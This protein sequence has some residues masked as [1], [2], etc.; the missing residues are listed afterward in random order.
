M[1][2][3]SRTTSHCVSLLKPDLAY[4]EHI[5][6][7]IRLNAIIC[8]ARISMNL[9]IASVLAEKKQK[10]LFCYR[11]GKHG[12]TIMLKKQKH[13]LLEYD[14]FIGDLATLNN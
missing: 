2:I 6:V 8:N 7:F 9:V 13:E 3:K 11:C 12:V 5:Q 4:V 14:I 1:A 10:Q